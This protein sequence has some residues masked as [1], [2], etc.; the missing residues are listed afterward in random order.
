[1]PTVLAEDFEYDG[2]PVFRLNKI[3]RKYRDIFI[4]MINSGQIKIED[5]KVCP[6]GHNKFVN[7]S[8]KDR[9]GL[10]FR[11]MLCCQCGLLIT[12]P[13]I[14]ESSL[15]RYYREVYHPLIVGL[16]KGEVAEHLVSVH[17]GEQIYYWCEPFLSSG[18]KESLKILEIGCATGSNLTSF[19]KKAGENGFHFELFGSEYEEENARAAMQKGINIIT[20]GLGAIVKSGIKIDIIILSHVFEHLIDLS[21]CLKQLKEIL[22]SNGFIYVEV[23]GFMNKEILTNWYGNNFIDYTVHAHIY[24]FNL[25]SLKYIFELS[26]Y[27]MIHGDEFIRAIFKLSQKEKGEYIEP[28]KSNYADTISYINNIPAKNNIM[29]GSFPFFLKHFLKKHYFNSFIRK[30]YYN[31]IQEKFDLSRIPL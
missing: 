24:N 27:E 12:N 11:N 10:P 30:I 14:A 25:A 2:L 26:G 29:K 3:R 8:N 22:N 18:G 21:L 9:F 23:P 5:V 16:E 19:A 31:N 20:G 28:P 15:E 13:R 7:I 1:M 4:K 17:Q 6:C